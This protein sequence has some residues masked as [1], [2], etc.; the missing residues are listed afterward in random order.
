MFAER[1][2][3]RALDCEG[4]AARRLSRTQRSSAFELY[5]DDGGHWRWRLRLGR[6]D[7]ADSGEGYERKNGALNGIESVKENAKVAAVT[8]LQPA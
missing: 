6:A 5:K 4:A 8:E 7:L 2:R 1:M 3:R